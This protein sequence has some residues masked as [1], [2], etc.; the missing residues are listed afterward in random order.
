MGAHGI[1]VAGLAVFR[2]EW[3]SGHLDR[4]R[5]FDALQSARGAAD[6]AGSGD[7]AGRA[8]A[9]VADALKR[10]AEVEATLAGQFNR[11]CGI[12]ENRAR[13]RRIR[14]PVEWKAVAEASDA[15][16]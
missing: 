3:V 9:A 8:Q 12:L 10:L 2:A 4:L 16:E 7:A 15:T 5:A 13:P 11:F 14:Q 1:Q 6:L